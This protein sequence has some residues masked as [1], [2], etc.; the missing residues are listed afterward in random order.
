MD[1]VLKEGLGRL[2]ASLEEQKYGSV[3]Q[4]VAADAAARD[5][6]LVEVWEWLKSQMDS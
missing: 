5:G 4:G 3:D 1:P 2:A 6:R